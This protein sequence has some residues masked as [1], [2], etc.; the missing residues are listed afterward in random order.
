MKLLTAT[1]TLVWV[2]GAAL[3]HAEERVDFFDLH[4]RR[5]GFAIVDEKTGRVDFYDVHSRRTG[6]GRV[7]PSGNVE[8]FDLKGQRQGDTALPIRRNREQ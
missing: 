6:W 4:G 2:L 7:E 1:L 5:T 3:L 8:R